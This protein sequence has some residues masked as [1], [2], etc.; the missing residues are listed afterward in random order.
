MLRVLPLL[1]MLALVLSAQPPIREFSDATLTEM[2]KEGATYYYQVEN[3]I[4]GYVGTSRKKLL[5]T[6]DETVKVALSGK[7]L[8]IVDERGKVQKT[9]FSLQFKKP[10]V[11]VAVGQ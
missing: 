1:L 2:A 4:C 8:Y 3:P 6:Q 10:P 5:V 11:P 7:W 9:R